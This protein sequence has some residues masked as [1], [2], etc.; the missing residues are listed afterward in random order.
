MQEFTFGA[1]DICGKVLHFT[2]FLPGQ[3]SIKCLSSSSSNSDKQCRLGSSWK[4]FGKFMPRRVIT[5]LQ[6]LL[7][8]LAVN[9]LILTSEKLVSNSMVA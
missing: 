9:F 3:I 4:I 8:T 5:I 1:F 6:N 7:G 2:G